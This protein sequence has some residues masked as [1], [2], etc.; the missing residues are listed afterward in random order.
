MI[1]QLTQLLNEKTE[2]INTKA[3]ELES[4]ERIE[5]AKIEADMKLALFKANAL[6][7]QAILEQEITEAQARQNLV[8]INEPIPK[9]FNGS[10][11]D[12]AMGPQQPQPTGG[13]PGTYMGV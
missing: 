5:F 4:K 6:A 1:Q 8:G 2:L 3:L 11:P 9:D 13:Q 12:Q 10:S 7:S